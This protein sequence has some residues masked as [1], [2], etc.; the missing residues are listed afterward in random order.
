LEDP[1]LLILDNH[2]FHLLIA[3]INVAKEIGV[4]MLTFLPIHHINY[5]HWTA[6][7]LVHIKHIIMLAL[8]TGCSQAQA[9]V[10]PFKMLQ[11]KMTSIW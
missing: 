2:E 11:V 10:Y 8:M 6:L 4:V 7:S 3:A 5:S 1:A 9:N